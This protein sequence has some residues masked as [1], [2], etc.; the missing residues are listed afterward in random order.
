MFGVPNG[1]V[2]HSWME[3]RTY[4]TCCAE[5]GALTTS[6]PSENLLPPQSLISCRTN[7][8]LL[9]LGDLQRQKAH[10]YFDLIDEDDDG[11]ID[12]EDF[13]G[14]ADRL[15]QKRALT[16]ENARQTLRR[17]MTKWWNDLC[18]AIDK[19]EDDRVSRNEWISFWEAIQTAVEQSKN[20]NNPVLESLKHSAEVTFDAIDTT[21]NGRVSEEEYAEWLAVWGANGSSEAFQ[22]LDRNDDGYLTQD[23][24][25]KATLEFYL[26]NDSEAP[27]NALYGP[28][29]E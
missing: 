12:V 13:E 22:R 17:Q 2:F 3:V 29:P 4:R 9:M 23:N 7:S 19:N 5:D 18:T 25:L 28:L 15:L 16:D 6:E 20:Q 14:R 11:V 26:S 10:Y 21:G 8:L 24:L 1:I 27:G